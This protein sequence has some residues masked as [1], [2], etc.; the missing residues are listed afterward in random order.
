MNVY[1]RHDALAQVVDP[2]THVRK[3]ILLPSSGE[4]VPGEVV[5]IIGPSGAGIPPP[6]KSIPDVSWNSSASYL[7]CPMRAWQCQARLWPA[8]APIVGTTAGLLPFTHAHAFLEN[9]QVPEIVLSTR[10]A[11]I[12]CCSDVVSQHSARAWHVG[13]F[14]ANVWHACSLLA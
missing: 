6:F 10:Y 2:A 1:S 12:S 4:A 13:P 5:A 9:L 8:S 11:G 7:L 3:Q 14:S